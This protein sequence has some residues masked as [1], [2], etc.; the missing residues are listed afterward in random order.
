MDD[1]NK[2]ISFEELKKKQ[3]DDASKIEKDTSENTSKAAANNLDVNDFKAFMDS[4]GVSIDE[5]MNKQLLEALNSKEVMDLVS[6]LD[7]NS[8]DPSSIGK[9]ASEMKSME[10]K[11]KR[12]QISFR[13]FSQW[14]PFYKPYKFENLFPIEFLKDMAKSLEIAL[15]DNNSKNEI[16]RKIY[17]NLTVYLNETFKLLG[18]DMLGLIG[19]VVYNEGEMEFNKILK[20][21]EELKIDFLMSKCLIARVKSNN[22]HK[23]V[24]PKDVMENIEKIDFVKIDKYNELNQKLVKATIGFINSYGIV[25]KKV[26]IEKLYSILGDSINALFEPSEF[27]V[28]LEKLFKFSFTESIVKRGL[29]PNIVIDGEYIHHAV[30]GFTQSLIDIQNESIKEYKHYDLEE[31]LHRGDSYFY[32]E[33]LYLS[34]IIEAIMNHN[35]IKNEDIEDLKNLIFTFS[36]LEFEPSLIMRM[37]EINYELPEGPRYEL[38]IETMRDFYKNSEKWILK[39]Y[40]PHETNKSQDDKL[41]KFDAS[42]IVNIDFNKNK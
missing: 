40:T 28:H 8:L 34:K 11:Y 4:M 41:S 6:K 1:K 32:E 14:Q 15:N 36:K 42:K 20:E 35:D 19:Q 38:F 37:I 30:V 23:L 2:V 3:T 25:P 24:I 26:L 29:Y 21:K 27:E 5:S 39:G 17:P 33:S 18:R 10:E 9:L 22:S 7:I 31:L 13:A 16:I 12:E